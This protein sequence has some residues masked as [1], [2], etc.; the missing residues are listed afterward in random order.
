M[1]SSTSSRRQFAS[2]FRRVAPGRS[3]RRPRSPDKDGTPVK[4][5]EVTFTV[6]EP[7]PKPQPGKKLEKP[8]QISQVKKKTD[9]RGRVV[10]TYDDEDLKRGAV[11]DTVTRTD[12]GIEKVTDVP[13]EQAVKNGQ[14][15]L[16]QST[17]TE[18]APSSTM[19]RG[20]RTAYT[21]RTRVH[22]DVHVVQPSYSGLEFLLGGDVGWATARNHYDDFP[23]F[24]SHGFAGGGHLG[25]RYYFQPNVFAGFE[26]GGLGTGIRGTI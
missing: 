20:G 2:S 8:R 7:S 3:H 14:I 13:L 11:I 17:A 9:D 6:H 26:F 22:E 12:H 18:T 15:R 5:Q 24:D 16:A 21:V 1:R 23:A 25:M 19:H 4:S 10:L